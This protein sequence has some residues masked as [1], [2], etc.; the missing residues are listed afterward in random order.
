MK[1][2]QMVPSEQ[3]GQEGSRRCSA[4][5]RTRICST[6]SFRGRNGDEEEQQE[7]VGDGRRMPIQQS[8]DVAVPSSRSGSSGTSTRTSRSSCTGSSRRRRSTP[9]TCTSREDL[10]HQPRL[11]REDHREAH[12]RD[13]RLDERGRSRQRR[14]RHVPQAR[15]APHPRRAQPRREPARPD[16]EDRPRHALHEAGGPSGPAPLQGLCRDERG[17]AVKAPKTVVQAVTQ[18]F[19]GKHPNRW[20]ASV[21]ATAIGGAV[22]VTVYRALRN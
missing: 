2:K 1:L 12:A 17:V 5:Q 22:G 9:S 4:P 21:A 6:S 3:A 7:G 14:R 10:G 19:G 11:G 15:P 18:R 16:R 20:R 13:D 8:V